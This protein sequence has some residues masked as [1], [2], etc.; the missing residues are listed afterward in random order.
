[1]PSMLKNVLMLDSIQIIDFHGSSQLHV[2][3]G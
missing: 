1:M 2:P 3:F